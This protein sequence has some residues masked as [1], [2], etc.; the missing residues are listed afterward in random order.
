MRENDMEKR[1]EVSFLMD[2]YG[3][4]LTE[5]QQNSI[6]LY[7]DADLSLGEIAEDEGIS[8]QGVRDAIRRSEE[9]MYDM[10]AKL[11]LAQKFINMQKGLEAISRLA[12]EI[13][14]HTDITN[15][16]RRTKKIREIVDKLKD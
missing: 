15:I 16:T 11:H 8:R 13:D 10:E 9:L 1:F 7:H 6:K 3:N 5:K 2:F 12:G 4:L 14:L